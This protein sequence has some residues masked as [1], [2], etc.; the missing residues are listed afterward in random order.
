MEHKIAVVLSLLCL[1]LA[2]SHLAAAPPPNIVLLY[3]DD[4]GYGDVSCY[5]ASRL[6]TPNID[7]L[8]E[9]GLRFTD[10]HSA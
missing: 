3:A 10:A 1:S 4:L 9:E 5:G 7:R 6:K 8:A 2:V